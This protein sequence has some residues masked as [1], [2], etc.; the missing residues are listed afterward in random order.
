MLVNTNNF[1]ESISGEPLSNKHN[2]RKCFN[3]L[4]R[5]FENKP[6]FLHL[7]TYGQPIYKNC[8]DFQI[9]G[10]ANAENW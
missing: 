9:V 7:N 5:P 6:V 1:L 10:L 2:E 3:R 8:V 4:C